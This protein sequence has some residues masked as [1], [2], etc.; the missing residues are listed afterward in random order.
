MTGEDLKFLDALGKDHAERYFA[1]VSEGQ[2]RREVMDL[3]TRSYFEKLNEWLA[4]H[5][6]TK[7]TAG[8]A[9]ASV[10]FSFAERR[11]ELEAAWQDSGGTA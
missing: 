6:P 9:L 4:G 10:M 2:D 3:V 5:N 11:A 7:E 8:I 1:A